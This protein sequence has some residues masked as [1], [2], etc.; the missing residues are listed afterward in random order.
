MLCLVNCTSSPNS[1]LVVKFSLK[2]SYMTIRKKMWPS[3]WTCGL[4]YLVLLCHILVTSLIYLSLCKWQWSST[5]MAL[6]KGQVLLPFISVFLTISPFSFYFHHS[7]SFFFLFP[8]FLLYLE[9][10]K[11]LKL[12]NFQKVVIDIT[13]SRHEIMGFWDELGFCVAFGVFE[14]E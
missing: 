3:R 2:M 1:R 11:A 14:N 5:T 6:L 7:F 9:L 12:H 13:P 10:T 4:L 8:F